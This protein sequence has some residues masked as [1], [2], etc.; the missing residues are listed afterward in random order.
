MP[1]R[2]YEITVQC[3]RADPDWD[4]FVERCP[5]GSHVQTARWAEV[6]RIVGWRA[7]RIA[8]HRDGQPIAGCQLLL[9]R[10]GSVGSLAYAPRGPVLAD[11]AG[12][13]ALDAILDALENLA[14]R[15]RVHYLKV[16]PSAAGEET[17][18][19]LEARG[20]VAS[21]LEA[22]PTATVLVDLR[23][24]PEEILAG[25]RTNTRRNIRRAQGA[26]V[27]VR[28]GDERD[29]GTLFRL[30]EA[31]GR[32]QSF[33][34]YPARYYEKIWH[35]FASAG[36]AQL[37]LAE[38]ESRA[39]AA[40]LL[41]AFGETVVYKMGGWGGEGAS[42][43][44][45]ELM[46]WAAIK[47]AREHG[48]R[49]YD[50]EGIDAGVARALLAGEDPPDTPERRL[51]HFKLGFAGEITT[52]PSAYDYSPN[53]LLQAML[54]RSGPWLERLRPLAFRVLGRGS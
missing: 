15:E 53:P 32:R 30:I 12:V 18:A 36:H 49:Y 28:A 8:L 29:L 46:H 44:P 3:D 7:T 37:L 54:R 10:L 31:T 2:P 47:W 48:H 40:A 43:R 34:P 17:Q 45:N 9:R 33:S 23:R 20:Y 14:R 5:G 51:S 27:S 16:Q 11:S 35:S 22:A 21:T 13:E 50:L 25:M 52:F 39:L 41:V 26:G 19:R 6:K 42:M 1:P 4:A 38:H 24:P